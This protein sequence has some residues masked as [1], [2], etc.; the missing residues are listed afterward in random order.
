[1]EL[2]HNGLVERGAAGDQNDLRKPRAV[3]ITGRREL[4]PGLRKIED[5]PKVCGA[6]PGHVRRNHPG[7]RLDQ[8]V[9]LQPDD[10]PPV[11]TH[12]ERASNVDV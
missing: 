10:A 7:G 11:D 3:R 12:L 8:R 2:T 4:R 5:R 1:M 6:V 9:G